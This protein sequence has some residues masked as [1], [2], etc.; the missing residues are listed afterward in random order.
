MSEDKSP[1]SADIR[2]L[3][4][5][6]GEIIIE[7]AGIEVYETVEEIRLLSKAWRDGDEAAN[8]RLGVIVSE[9]V[10]DL[11]RT[12][13]I[14][15]AF[16]TYF[17]L[18]N[19]AEE[20]H[21]IQIL[22]GRRE[23]AF[24]TNVA[25]DESIG[26]AIE[27]L[28]REQF[29]TKEIQRRLS[30][31]RVTPV[32]TAHPTEAKRLT[33]R[34]ILSYLS[35]Q[36]FRLRSSD[37]RSF[38]QPEVADNLRAAITLLW[39]SDDSRK[40]KPTVMDEVRSTSFYFFENTLFDV[41]PQIYNALERTIRKHLPDH[42]NE[43]PKILDF[44]T[45][46]GGDRDG[47]PFVT[48]ETTELAIRSQKDCVLERYADDVFELY[49]L[50]S[51]SR[52]RAGFDR[53][54]LNQLRESIS[55]LDSIDQETLLR[56]DQEPYRQ[57]LIL[58]F[59]KLKRTQRSNQK[60]WSAPTDA[61]DIYQSAESLLDE[62]A[63][64]KSSLEN[65]A[66]SALARGKLESL[67]RRVKVFGF[68]LTSMD[69]RQHSG[70]HENAIAE[71]LKQVRPETD[72]LNLDR[73][74]R[75]QW[76]TEMIQSSRVEV[77]NLSP[78]TAEI[79]S[80]FTTVQTAHK[81]TGR[82][83]I[84]SYIVSMTEDESD[85]L[86]VLWFL[87]QAQLFGKI[88]VVPLFET[89]AD[90]RAAPDVMTRLF[91][92][93][94]YQK[95]LAER[96]Q[97][98]QIMIGYSDSNKDGSFLR[99]NWMLF[100]AQRQLAQTCAK[101]DI[102]MTL[103]HGRGGSIGRGGG[104]ANRSILSQPPESVLGR[105]RITEQGEVVTSRYTHSD[106]AFRHLQQLL[107]AVICSTG[108]RPNY[109]KYDRWVEIMDEVSELAY[110]KYRALVDHE[111]F[112]EYF[113]LATPIDLV[114][115]MNLGS[116]PAKR[117]ET[118]GIEDLRA[119]PW[120]FSWSQS[121][122]NLPS[123][124]GVGS[125]FENWIRVEDQTTERTEELQDMYQQWP[126]FRSV[127]DNVHLGMGRADIQISELY[128]R[129]CKRARSHELFAEIKTEFELTRRCLLQITGHQEILDTEPWLQNSIR[130]RNP[131]VDPMNYIQVALLEKLRKTDN[132]AEMET[133]QKV[134]LQTINGIAAGLQN[135]G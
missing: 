119:I 111:D 131:Y 49:E 132:P 3:G 82:Q 28:L 62:L 34:R 10:G 6:L 19:L 12:A 5:M 37:L 14:V 104:P 61:D 51:P 87:D 123:W 42:P 93:P 73:E 16:S 96:N 31:T 83:S 125:A 39:Q 126:F 20:H 80:L 45:W 128:S 135:V 46:I 44:G 24:D 90:L 35:Q 50:L 107:N 102:R 30:E 9:L 56:F 118:H 116:R 117:R 97:A 112:I 32:F 124:F 106:I 79:A 115:Q 38:E 54:F 64:I 94:V 52:D 22:R 29:T 130:R 77:R 33:T 68:H 13:D 23:K 8:E 11:E 129:L 17:G 105:I 55:K 70:K 69:I 26:S 100:I 72:Y 58:I 57:K 81:Q 15:K 25:M 21:R 127:L 133:I 71:I 48:S 36:L 53:E 92:N 67:I 43:A 60:P 41:V 74:Q 108:T 76:L 84:Q 47:N 65:H 86:E 66:G 91:E 85:L 114:G 99:A 75:C 122:T 121:R 95:H 88:D 40:R 134:I 1:L 101:H 4:G 2:F 103:F 63:K 109:P 59:R 98:Q 78:E 110:R 27:T 18:V 120:V 7:Q 113:H 89:V